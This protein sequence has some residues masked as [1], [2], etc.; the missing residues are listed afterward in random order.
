LG[1]ALS[2]VQSTQR[3]LWSVV[4]FVAVLSLI[5]EL[6]QFGFDERFP[7]ALDWMMNILGTALGVVCSRRFEKHGLKE[8]LRM[9]IYR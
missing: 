2:F 1:F 8:T 7:S 3:S 5:V 4:I 6:L 9:G